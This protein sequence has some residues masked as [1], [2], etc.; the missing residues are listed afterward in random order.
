MFS[1][2][3]KKPIDSKFSCNECG[4]KFTRKV[5]LT[6]HQLNH[7]GLRPHACSECGRVFTRRN[8][9]QRHEKIH[10]RR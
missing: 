5:A 2:P 7:K 4:K 9:C 1:L 6:H 10:A 8:D 3:A